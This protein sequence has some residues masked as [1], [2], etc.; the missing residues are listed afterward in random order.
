MAIRLW[1]KDELRMA[2]ALYCQLPFGKLDRRNSEIIELAR[3]IDRTPASVA[4]KLGNFASLD[5]VIFNSGRKGLDNASKL[6]REIWAEF[7]HDWDKA[8]SDCD[9]IIFEKTPA[10][11]SKVDEGGFEEAPSPFDYS[12]STR[13]IIS[14]QRLKQSFFRRAILSGY[15][16]RCCLTGISEP[17]LLIASH[18][19]PWSVDKSNRLNPS[20]GL[21]LSAIHDKAFDKGLIT[22]ADD[23]SV[24]LS[25]KLT[26]CKSEFMSQAFL[27]LA[28]RKIETPERFAPK[29]DFIQRHR[30]EVFQR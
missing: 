10:H 17:N 21:C 26:D 11:D 22:F 12:G 19:V 6:D 5:P 30:S 27:S 28:G 9:S 4:M 2:Y 29:L 13:E 16:N 3:L 25:P 18:I 8:V 1:A 20:N 24:I 7:H 23:L 15:R 14:N